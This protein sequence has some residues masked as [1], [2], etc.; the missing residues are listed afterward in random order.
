MLLKNVIHVCLHS[1][2]KEKRKSVWTYA[3][4]TQRCKTITKKRKK[5]NAF[6]G[7]FVSSNR[8]QFSL[9]FKIFVFQPPRRCRADRRV[10]LRTGAGSCKACVACRRFP[11]APGGRSVNSSLHLYFVPRACAFS[12]G[13]LFAAASLTGRLLHSIRFFGAWQLATISDP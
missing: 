12:Y 9:F 6:S 13:L 10:L 7:A 1:L 11:R 5:S 3:F 4:A 2:Q 8:W